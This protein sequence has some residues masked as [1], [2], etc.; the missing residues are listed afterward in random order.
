MNHLV[1][2]YKFD[3][4]RF[5]ILIQINQ[6]ETNIKAQCKY[7]NRQYFEEMEVLQDIFYVI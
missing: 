2:S 6:C 1:E 5:T 4:I 7:L 3:Q